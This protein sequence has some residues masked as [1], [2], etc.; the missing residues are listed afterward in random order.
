[1]KKIKAVVVVLVLGVI[2]LFPLSVSQKIGTLLGRF[3]GRNK[4]SSLY[5]ITEQNIAICFP[6][7]DFESRQNL[8]EQSLQQTGMMAAEA[9]M[10][11]LSSPT[12]ILKKVRD[13]KGESLIYE[14]LN[15]GRGVLLIAPHLG[16]WEV[17]NL[18]ISSRHPTTAM[19]RPPKLKLL[20]DLIKKM[21]ERLGTKMAPA[22]SKGVRMVLKSLKAGELVGIL[23]DQEP[24]TLNGGIYAPFF[25]RDAL[26][27][28]LFSQL[29]K[30][31]G[32]RVITGY[33]KR[34]PNARGYS[35]HFAE[36]HDAIY[37]KELSESVTGLNL[38]IEKCVRECP[39]QY[40]WEYKRFNAQPENVDSPYKKSK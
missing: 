22:D 13:V 36:A 33:A 29:V 25:G 11:W 1:M 38:S 17:L 24:A 23:P 3:I 12:R 27:M 32:A 40:Q 37:S 7:Y 15:S 8:I 20:D 35:I 4:D 5:R 16:N 18:Y 6:D 39:E 14:T 9:G 31:T 2:S 10:S 28:K 19:Y 26:T 30:Q 21:R 34:L